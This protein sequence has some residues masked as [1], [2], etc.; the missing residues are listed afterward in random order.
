MDT[1]NVVQLDANSF[2]YADGLTQL[3]KD[4]ED[5]FQRDIQKLV[6]Q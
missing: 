6:F 5:P 4:C 3:M 2:K 1:I